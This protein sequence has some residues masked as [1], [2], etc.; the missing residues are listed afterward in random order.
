MKEAI[1]QYNDDLDGV[2]NY[3]VIN[4]KEFIRCKDCKHFNHYF[5]ECEKNNHTH[6]A[7]WFC[8]D[9]VKKERTDSL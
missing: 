7:N 6:G 2:C 9:G 8:G 1:I 3:F 5:V 4:W